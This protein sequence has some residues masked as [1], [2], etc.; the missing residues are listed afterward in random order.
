MNFMGGT[1]LVCRADAACFSDVPKR[2]ALLV[3]ALQLA[4][5]DYKG[6]DEHCC[7]HAQAGVRVPLSFATPS[8]VA[9]LP[10]PNRLCR[11]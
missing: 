6:G 11:R 8:F 9:C 3:I 2:Y 10:V 4:C 1:F 7:S 5:S